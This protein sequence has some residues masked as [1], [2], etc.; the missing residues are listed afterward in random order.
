[1]SSVAIVF[2]KDKLNKK[3][4]APIHFRIIKDRKINYIASGIMLNEK[5]WDY[6]KIK[7]KPSYTNSARVNNFLSKKYSELNDQVL[8]HETNH[9]SLSV[10]NLK[11]KIY[12]K[13]PTD[14]FSFANRIIQ[15]YL[16]EGKVTTHDRAQSIINKLI[17]YM[18]GRS[19]TFQDITPEFIGKYEEYLRKTLS[20]RTNT[21]HQNLKFLR[22]LFND[23][24]RGGYI[25][26]QQ[27]PFLKYQL[28]QEK[29]QRHYLTEKELDLIENISLEPGTRLELHRDMFVF[30]AYAGGLRISDVLQLRW[31]NYD[32]EHIHI[33]VKKTGQQ[34]SI[35]LP[36][37]AIT[38]IKRYMPKKAL[39]K[40]FIFPMLHS[41]LNI[42]DVR[43]IDREIS[44]ST[45]FINKNLKIISK[46]AG[47]SKSV[48]FHVSRHTWATLALKKGISIDKVSKLMGHAAIK[49]TQIYAKIL[50]Q[51]LD[52]AM[53][54]FNS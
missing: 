47:V 48:S 41:G 10:H 27:I 52:K 6:K 51:E 18:K 8:E 12:G 44:N 16:D 20:N 22:K 7:V 46:R 2:R 15:M 17:A 32:G 13:K 54:V 19:L 36:N 23:A 43:A 4:Q 50:S 25:E 26:H 37:K 38:I 14:F 34:L 40:E 53:E 30:A 35:K 29:T 28:K 31:V 45:A 21:I 11:E 24:Y 5:Y 42:D 39:P 9:K 3:S 33:S 1:M 49:E